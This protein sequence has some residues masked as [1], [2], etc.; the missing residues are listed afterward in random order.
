VS[1]PLS[2]AAGIE[3]RNSDGSGGG[4]HTFVFGF[5]SPVTS[6]DSIST[7]CGIVVS[8]SVDPT[9]SNRYLVSVN[10]AGCNQ[11]YVTVSLTGVHSSTAS[12]KFAAN[13]KFVRDQ[14]LP[15]A[16]VTAGL[17]IGDVNGSGRVD[18]ADVSF[19]R[20]QTLQ[21]ITSANYRADVNGTGRIDSADVSLVRQQTLTSLP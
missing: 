6:V 9:N 1:L 8:S 19:V 2:G 13:H 18:A 12:H 4:N 11:Q 20:Q 10:A 17:L 21:P 3:C 14:A 15:S 7:T 16:S 5:T